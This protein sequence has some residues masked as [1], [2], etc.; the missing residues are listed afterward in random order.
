[1]AN[2]SE[3]I[4]TRWKNACRVL[5]G[6]EVGDITKFVPWLTRLNEPVYHRKTS[7]SGK[8]VS[9]A[10]I[11]YSEKS[12]WIS[13]DEID[14]GKKYSP[15][16]INEIKDID[17]IV[18]ALSDRFYYAGNVILGNS[19]FVEKSANISDSF[20]MYET[21]G[22]TDSK[23]IGYSTHG[24][25]NEDCFGCN[26]I[27]ESQFCIKCC[28]TFHNKRCFELWMGQYCSDC[29][30]S[31]N[32]SACQDCFFCFNVKNMRNAIGNLALEK[33]KYLQLKKKLLSEMAQMLRD[34]KQLPTLVE[35]VQ[36]STLDSNTVKAKL[37]AA[38]KSEAFDKKEIEEAFQKTTSIILGKPLYH[39]IDNYS[40]WLK[41]H[42]RKNE[43]C[44]SVFS[45]T[46]LH[47]WD[48]CCYFEL[49]KDRLVTIDEAIAIG[50]GSAISS[51]EAETFGIKT[52]HQ[53]IGDI[54]FFSPEYKD[55]TN[56]NLSECPNA[57]DSMNCYRSSPIVYSKY[58]GYSFWPRS[59]EYAFGC[60]AL[61]SSQF[62]INCY[63]SV[64][65]TRCFELDSSRNCSDCL[66]S[67]NIENC[68]D[69]MFCFNVKNMKY[70]VGNIEVGKEQYARIKKLVLEEI[71]RKVES[72]KLVPDIYSIGVS[73]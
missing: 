60:G 31:H 52:A 44:S 55:G 28:E 6:E 53:M 40:E 24:R 54:A 66:F 9:Y 62:C 67:H 7:I 27:G 14:F 42:T 35:I 1:M 36:K 29:Y 4:N 46:Q 33:S 47:R 8:E 2:T 72:G 65:L 34:D 41:K 43:A 51:S 25:L 23:Y 17:S 13:F 22:L 49:P 69:C 73:V 21:T 39:G 15:L 32:L 26:G 61:L 3:T 58:C 19:G 10:H 12:K 68:Q 48:Y 57:S 30:Y 56:L 59:S 64:K 11:D 71:V 70:V 45:K 16:S 5:F 50:A 37:S 20:Y 18:S 63:H 38:K